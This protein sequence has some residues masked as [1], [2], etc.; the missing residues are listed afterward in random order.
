[1]ISIRMESR[2]ELNVPISNQFCQLGMGIA[3]VKVLTPTDSIA[4][5]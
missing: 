5:T 4:Q 3:C 1:M 2:V